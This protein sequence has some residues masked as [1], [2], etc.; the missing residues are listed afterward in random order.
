M[1][2]L[3]DSEAGGRGALGKHSF[4]GISDQDRDQ[5]RKRASMRAEDIDAG[6]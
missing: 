5:R 4:I 2:N 3:F 1:E 6:L